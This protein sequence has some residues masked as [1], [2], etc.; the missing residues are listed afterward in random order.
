MRLREGA[1]QTLSE[2]A[3]PTVSARIIAARLCPDP[4]AVMGL[5]MVVAS[6][7]RADQHKRAHSGQ[8]GGLQRLRTLEHP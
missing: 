8:Q 6:D 2:R 7:D 1:V 5:M 4:R 3:T